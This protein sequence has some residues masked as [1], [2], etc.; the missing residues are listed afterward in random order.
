[1]GRGGG[2]NRGGGASGGGPSQSG[3]FKKKPPVGNSLQQLP[4][5]NSHM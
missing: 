5:A 4:A 1:M 2:A 3:P